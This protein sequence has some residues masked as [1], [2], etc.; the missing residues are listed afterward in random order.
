MNALP[1]TQGPLRRWKYWH[2][3]T[4]VAISGGFGTLTIFGDFS[5]YQAW[6]LSMVLLQSWCSPL[7]G[8]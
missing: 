8:A 3:A 4:I 7:G 6:W 2:S 5:P 1:G